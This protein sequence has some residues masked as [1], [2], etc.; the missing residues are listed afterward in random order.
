MYAKY[1]VLHKDTV[2]KLYLADTH[3]SDVQGVEETNKQANI[4]LS[5]SD[6][7]KQNQTKTN[8]MDFGNYTFTTFS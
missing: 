7:L 6:E 4:Q 2:L 5:W 8:P 3:I 1:M